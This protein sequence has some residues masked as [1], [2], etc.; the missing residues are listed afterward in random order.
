MEGRSDP[1]YFY[2]HQKHTHNRDT[3]EEQSFRVCHHEPA[4]AGEGSAFD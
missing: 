4:V 2:C 3:E 1:A